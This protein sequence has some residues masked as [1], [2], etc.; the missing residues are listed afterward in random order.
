[1]E[2]MLR[3]LD[4]NQKGQLGRIFYGMGVLQQFSEKKIIYMF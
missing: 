4:D 1:M 3:Q 2:L